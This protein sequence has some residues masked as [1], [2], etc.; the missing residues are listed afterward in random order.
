MNARIPWSP[1]KQQKKA[2]DDTIKKKSIEVSRMLGNNMDASALWALHKTFGFGKK[3]LRRFYDAF[4]EERK[5]L[6]RHYEMDGEADYLCRTK[7]KEIGVDIEAWND[8]FE[9]KRGVKSL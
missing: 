7:L 5:V 1:S 2:M 9:K 3:R 6:E 4:I 8:E